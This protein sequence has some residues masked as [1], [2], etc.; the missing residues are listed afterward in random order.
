MEKVTG[1]DGLACIRYLPYPAEPADRIS[2]VV[3]DDVLSAGCAGQ[4]E[5]LWPGFE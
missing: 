4:V 1:E 5:R 3:N 2:A